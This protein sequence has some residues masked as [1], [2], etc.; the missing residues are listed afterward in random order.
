MRI[1]QINIGSRTVLRVNGKKRETGIFKERWEGPISVS[2]LGLPADAICNKKHH[3][4]P[5]QAIYLYS[6]ED[7]ARWEEALGKAVPAGTFGENFTTSGQALTEICVGDVLFSESVILQVAAPR[8]PCSTLAARM[9]DKQFAKKFM[10]AGLSGAYCRVL[11]A[12]HAQA[13]DVFAHKPF[14]G[15]RI[16]LGTFFKHAHIELS[17]AALRRYLAVP[18]DERTR[19]KFA[20]KL[21][22]S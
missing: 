3:G 1:E 19:Q 16:P 21:A 18:I 11:Q 12:G 2:E 17:S 4:G 22:A 15:D 10:K 7:Y 14:E 6:V 20:K 9:G 13:G 8:I 5:D